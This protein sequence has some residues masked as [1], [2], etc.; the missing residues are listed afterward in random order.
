MIEQRLLGL[1]ATL[2]P[3]FYGL[4]LAAYLRVFRRDVPRDQ[5]WTHRLLLA[6]LGLHLAT[7]LLAAFTLRRLPMA[8]PLEFCSLLAFCLVLINAV[9]QRLAGMRRTGFL[10][11][12]LAFLLQL[13][14]SAFRIGEP[15]AN[16]LLQD[17]GYSL[18]AILV[19]LAYTAMSLGFIYA[20]LYLVLARQLARRSFGLLFRRLPPLETLESLSVGAV[21]LGVPLLLG[22]LVS[23]MVWMRSLADKV[24]PELAARLSPWD[25]KIIASTIVLLAYCAGLAGHHFL[26]WRGRRMNLVAIGT[27]LCVILAMALVHHFFPSFHDFSL[28]GETA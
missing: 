23:G 5:V 4:L 14:A 8:T 25:P 11:A 10:V 21:R 19:L 26:G 17:P 15:P 6:T 13:I 1:A 7:I 18:H 27:F 28:R 16:P 3:L 2:L 20:L 22:S 24:P 12:G 9:L